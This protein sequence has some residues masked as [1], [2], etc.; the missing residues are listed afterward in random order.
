MSK[1]RPRIDLTAF[2]TLLGPDG[3]PAARSTVYRRMA[4]D[5]DCPKPFHDGYRLQFFLDES[6]EY[7][8]SRPR[9][10]YGVKEQAA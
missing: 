7:V 3:H 2:R 6:I 9:R 4:T 10:E 8:E 1:P 5:P